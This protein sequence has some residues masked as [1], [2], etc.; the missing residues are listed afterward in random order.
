MGWQ[1]LSVGP[2]PVGMH[3]LLIQ[4]GLV[5]SWRSRVFDV[6]IWMQTDPHTSG[7]NASIMPQLLEGRASSLT[8]H[9]CNSISAM[10]SGTPGMC[11]VVKM[12]S[13]LCAH[14]HSSFARSVRHCAWHVVDSCR[15]TDTPETSFRKVFAARSSRQLMCIVCF[16]TFKALTVQFFT[17]TTPSLIGRHLCWW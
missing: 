16:W 2:S 8:F 3:S 4:G 7:P 17:Q 9:V 11:W 15:S 12:I 5:S 14:I 10:V 13:L 1:S 6:A